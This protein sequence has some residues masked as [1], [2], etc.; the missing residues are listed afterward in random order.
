M[1]ITITIAHDFTCPWC[2]IGVFQALALR[3]EFGAELHWVGHELW[4]DE[5]EIPERSP[6]PVVATNRPATPTRLELAYA[7]QGMEP[8]TAEKVTGPR[9]HNALEAAAFAQTQGKGDSFIEL[10]YRAI[11]EESL[12]GNDPEVLIAL[13]TKVGLDEEGL[14]G[15][16]CGRSYEAEIIKFDDDSYGA[17]VYNVPTFF[18]GD[19]RYAEQPLSV[20]RKAVVAELAACKE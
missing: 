16:I 5:L 10:V 15:A 12:D 7:A 14:R 20:L 8:P 2:Y 13:G 1:P 19:Y 9:I 17:G 4:P 6:S 3:D 11:W 18:I